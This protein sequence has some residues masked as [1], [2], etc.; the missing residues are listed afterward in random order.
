MKVLITGINGFIASKLAEYLS[1]CCGM[2]VYGTSSKNRINQHC[3]EMFQTHEG[4]YQ[5]GDITFDWV[6]HFA[7]DKSGSIESNVSLTLELARYLKDNG[8]SNQV[9]ISSI[10]AV[11]GAETDYG[12]IKKRTEAWFIENRMYILRP[13]LVVGD[14]GLFLSMVNKV[15]KFPMLPLIN[16]GGQKIKLI[17]LND[18]LKQILLVLNGEQNKYELNLIY[19]KEYSLKD[20]LSC[21]ARFYNTKIIFFNIPYVVIY[22]VVRILEILRLDLGISTSNLKGLVTNEAIIQSDLMNDILLRDILEK[23]LMRT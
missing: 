3:I 13:G 8:V 18:L 9:F 4:E 15:R 19:V 6:V 22:F 12:I 10:S 16:N 2:D 5:F 21:I 1:V 14:G 7:Y 17:G 11:S 23:N 20:I